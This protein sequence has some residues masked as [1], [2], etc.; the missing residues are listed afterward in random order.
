MAP[1]SVRSLPD[2][3]LQAAVAHA[4]SLG[5]AV[6]L[7][8]GVLPGLALAGSEGLPFPADYVSSLA[9]WLS[10][11]AWNLSFYPQAS[12]SHPTRQR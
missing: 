10:S 6:L 11:A 9:G 5:L 2:T 4:N 3:V 8:A 7:L 1:S 12:C